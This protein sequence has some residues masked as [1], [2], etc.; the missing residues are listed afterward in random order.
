MFDCETKEEAA[1]I[2]E[3]ITDRLDEDSDILYV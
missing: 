2:I 3:K 1:E